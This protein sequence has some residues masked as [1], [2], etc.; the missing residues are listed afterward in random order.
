M[1]AYINGAAGTPAAFDG[2]MSPSASFA[3]GTRPTSLDQQPFGTIRNVK[4]RNV[5]K[6]A[7][8]IADMQ[9]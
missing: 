5:V 9:A 2:D 1:T 4:I 6:S 7:L 3:V 8:Q